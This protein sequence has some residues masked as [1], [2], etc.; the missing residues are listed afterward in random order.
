[1]VHAAEQSLFWIG[2]FLARNRVPVLLVV[3]YLLLSDDIVKGVRPHAMDSVRDPVG[4]TGLG[5]VLGGLVL[6]SWAAG[7]IRK[8]HELATSGPYGLM[9]HP[10]YIGS[11]LMAV[12]YGAIIDDGINIWVVLAMGL[13]FFALKMHREEISMTEKFGA[14]WQQY[15]EQTGLFFPQHGPIRLRAEWS[16][17]QW[18]RNKEDRAV[19]ASLAGL[20]ALQVWQS[21]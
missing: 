10:L 18:F 8:G 9:R 14:R 21:L 13:A 17:A 12:G 20:W 7:V 3:G 5:F 2:S 16:L 15:V 19:I 1:M 11:M 6:R 4:L